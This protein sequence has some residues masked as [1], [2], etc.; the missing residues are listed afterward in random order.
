MQLICKGTDLLSCAFHKNIN[1]LRSSHYLSKH[2]R[3]RGQLIN[4]ERRSA[5]AIHTQGERTAGTSSEGEV[6]CIITSYGKVEVDSR[7]FLKNRGRK[8]AGTSL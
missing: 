4:R 7:Y 2:R 1:L 8:K 5:G 3:V 6:D